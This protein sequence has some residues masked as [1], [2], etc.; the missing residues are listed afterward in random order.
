MNARGRTLLAI[1]GWWNIAFALLHVVIIVWGAGGYRY[2]GAGEGMARAAEA[3][4]LRPAVIT[5]LLTLMFVLWGLVAFSAAGIGRRVGIAKYA[6][7]LI[8]VLYILRG[9]LAGPQAVWMYQH[10]D[11]VPLRFVLFS[12]VALGLGIIGLWGVSLVW[13][14]SGLAVARPA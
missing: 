7:V 9:V 13:R 8:G 10:P 14:D 4:S 3:G 1:F 11:Q 12:L 5:G 2:F 6:V